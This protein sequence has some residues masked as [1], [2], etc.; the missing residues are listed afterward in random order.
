MLLPSKLNSFNQSVLSKF[1]IVL[2]VLKVKTFSPLDL[3][4]EVN[5]EINSIIEFVDVLD[6]LYALNKIE[7]DEKKEVIKYVDGNTM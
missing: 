5:K 6:C 7:Y 2:S 3:Y 4:M 1:T